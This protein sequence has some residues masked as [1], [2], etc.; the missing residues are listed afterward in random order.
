[1]T[2][3]YLDMMEDSLYK[4]I[5]VMQKIE[6]LNLK[7]NDILEN[8]AH[9]DSDGFDDA[10]RE[11]GELIDELIRLNDGF[12][13]LFDR[14]KEELASHKEEYKDQ[15]QR[16]Q[17]LIRQITDL[18]AI[19]EEEEHKNKN[20]AD[21]YFSSVRK[22]MK[23]GKQAAAAALNYHQV[24]NKAGDVRPQFFDDHS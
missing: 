3:T 16:M 24:M 18:S 19:L 20:L 1:M 10:V 14:T 22:E 11:K 17:E 2:A 13:I 7:Q 6:K 12:T 4:K 5:E 15:I 23:L 9:M 8:Q 21:Y